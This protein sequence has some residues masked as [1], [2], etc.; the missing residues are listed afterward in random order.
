MQMKKLIINADDFGYSYEVN[1]AVKLGV[2]SGFLTSASLLVNMPGFN[3]AV[4][5]LRLIPDIDLG[6]H[7]NIVEGQSISCANLLT[8]KNNIFNY[9]FINL[10]YKSYDKNF[11]IQIENEFRAQIETAL[12]YTGK[13][14]HID[15][16]VHIHA[17]PPIFNLVLKLA[18]DY[19][20]PFIRTQHE[21]PYFI[22]NKSLNKKFIINI[23]KNILLNLLTAINLKSLKNTNILT[24]DNFIGVLYTG[25]MDEQSI[26]GGLKKIKNISSTEL[27][28][29]PC[30]GNNSTP[31]SN[32][33]TEFL[34][35]QNQDLLLKIKNSDFILS[36]Y[37]DLLP[38]N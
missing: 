20:I 25:F 4:D 26:L 34:T 36:S 23:F 15:S 35:T 5:T 6:I 17:I 19:N 9:S 16:H 8:D 3:N 1:E 29:H 13:L 31:L 32:K 24:N 27:I 38:Q 2:L 33:I 11:L 10:F 14:S 30:Y 37:S 7:L 12:K 28:L 18:K 22:L 21:I